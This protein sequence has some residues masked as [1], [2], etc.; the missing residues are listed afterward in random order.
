MAGSRFNVS[1]SFVGQQMSRAGSQLPSSQSI[2][3]VPRVPFVTCPSKLEGVSPARCALELGV[4]SDVCCNPNVNNNMLLM[5]TNYVL[6][7]VLRALMD[8]LISFSWRYGLDCLGIP[9]L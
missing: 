7:T 6:I 1:S 9:I 5:S 8:H 2:Q 3:V 4:N